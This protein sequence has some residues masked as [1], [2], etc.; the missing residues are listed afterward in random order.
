MK[1]FFWLAVLL[2][3]AASAGFWS[4]RRVCQMAKPCCPVHDAKAPAPNAEYALPAQAHALCGAIC[5][6]RL[7]LIRLLESAEADRTAVERKVEEIGAMQ[8]SL[9][10]QIAAHILD[11]KASLPPDRARAYLAGIREQMKRAIR[12]NGFEEIIES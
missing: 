3:L 2:A 1:R 5:K 9:E 12:H 11:V 6:E 8:T 4:M 7:E 10:K